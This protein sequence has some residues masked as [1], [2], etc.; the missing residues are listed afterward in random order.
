M[1]EAIKIK[2]EIKQIQE[3]TQHVNL[4]RLRNLPKKK[5]LKKNFCSKLMQENNFLSKLYY[6]S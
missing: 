4:F 5:L 1:K 6:Y 2:T 3:S